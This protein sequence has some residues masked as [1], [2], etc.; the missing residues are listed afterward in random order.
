MRA[1]TISLS[2]RRKKKLERQVEKY[3]SALQTHRNDYKIQIDL[4][5]TYAELENIDKGTEAYYRAIELLR[6]APSV[7]KTKTLMI[8]LYEKIIALSPEAYRAYIELS[9]EYI[10]AGQK[11]KAFRFLLTSAKKAYEEE[12]Y[13][14]ALECYNQAIAKGRTNPHIVERCT[15]LYIKLGRINDAMQNYL[16]IGD[17]YAQDEKNIEAL[18]YYKKA[19]A[20]EPDNPELLLK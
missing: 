15:E 12:N 1:Q 5:D 10:A 20:L 3:L 2:G 17:M 8:E 7:G 14:L 11:E 9:E 16:Q 6:Q 13:E 18:E 19:C 4:G